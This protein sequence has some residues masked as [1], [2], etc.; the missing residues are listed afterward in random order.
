MILSTSTLF[1]EIEQ[2]HMIIY[3]YLRES[4]QFSGG[5]AVGVLGRGPAEGDAGRG[6]GRAG[7]LP[8]PGHRAAGPRH[9]CTLDFSRTSVLT[10]TQ[11]RT[12]ALE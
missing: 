7:V 5:A 10:V 1:R 3:D 9:D 8:R 2:K 6:Q 4:I 11:S 12:N